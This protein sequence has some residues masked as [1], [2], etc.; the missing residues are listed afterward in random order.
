M[1]YRNKYQK[2]YYLFKD[3]IEQIYMI[4]IVKLYLISHIVNVG[5]INSNCHFLCLLFGTYT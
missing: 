1:K 4:H 3:M 2:V 5:H